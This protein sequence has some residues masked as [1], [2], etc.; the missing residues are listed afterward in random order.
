MKANKDTNESCSQSGRIADGGIDYANYDL[1]P[2]TFEYKPDGPANTWYDTQNSRRNALKQLNDT[3][4][5]VCYQAAKARPGTYTGVIKGIGRVG[6]EAIELDT[7]AMATALR[8]KAQELVD[9][10]SEGPTAILGEDVSEHAD[11]IAAELEAQW[12]LGVEEVLGTH[13][14]EGGINVDGTTAWMSHLTEA[15]YPEVKHTLRHMDFEGAET[16]RVAHSPTMCCGMPSATKRPGLETHMHSTS[17]GSRSRLRL[18][19]S[20]PLSY[21]RQ[22]GFHEQRRVWSR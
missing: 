2:T 13:L 18:G 8:T 3:D 17:D 16:D 4:I 15:Y 10:R 9:S 20:E 14:H 1:E 7:D 6:V 12:Q 19:N 22:G 21:S 11:K 5:W